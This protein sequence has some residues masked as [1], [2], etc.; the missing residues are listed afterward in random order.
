M[1]RDDVGET[2]LE[3]TAD[4]EPTSAE[5]ISPR[6]GRYAILRKLGQG[7]MGVVYSAY[8]ESLDR[9]VAL[10]FVRAD[11]K[12]ANRRI[13]REAQAMGRLSHPNVVQ[14]YEFGEHDGDLF[15]AMEF[16][17]GQTLSAWLKAEA[18]TWDTVRDVF[19]KAGRGLAAAHSAGLIHRDFKPDNVLVSRDAGVKVLDFGLVRRSDS[20]SSEA[21]HGRRA[22]VE[23]SVTEAGALMGTPA[24][25][26][27]EQFRGREADA[28]TDQFSFCVALWEGL[29]GERPFSG[30]TWQ[31][32]MLAV[33]NGELREPPRSSVVPQWLRRVIERGLSV[34]PARRWPSMEELLDALTA[35]PSQ[36]RRIWLAGTVA[37]ALLAG[38]FLGIPRWERLEEQRRL[39]E[40]E[41]S[42]ETDA[43]AV[44]AVWTS[45]QREAVIAAVG[46]G[47]ANAPEYEK[48]QLERTLQHLDGYVGQL[49]EARRSACRST[50]VDGTQSD[51]WLELRRRC[52]DSRHVDLEGLIRVLAEDSG[53]PP[54]DPVMSVL[55][56]P[57]IDL[58][59]QDSW[60]ETQPN[61]PE[62]PLLRE[63]VVDL[64]QELAH[65]GV[66]ARVGR[67]EQAL[68]LAESVFEQATLIDWQPLA[69]SA[70][71]QMGWANDNLGNYELARTQLNE[72]LLLAGSSRND[73]SM[74]GAVAALAWVDAYRLG[75]P[76]EGLQWAQ[77]GLMLAKRLDIEDSILHAEVLHGQGIAYFV[78]E[79]NER[80]RAAF[81]RALEIRARVVGQT[82][83]MIAAGHV[84]LGSVEI[85]AR[86]DEAALEHFEAALSIYHASLGPFHGDVAVA[87]SNIGTVYVQ[88]K[89][90]S[91]GLE[92]YGKAVDLWE[93]R[94]PEHPEVGT[95]LDNIGAAHYLSGDYEAAR[96]YHLRAV[97]IFEKSFGGDHPM[98]GAALSGLGRDE[99][100]LGNE[101]AAL[102]ALE[103]SLEIL[104]GSTGFSS[105]LGATRETLA[106]MLW[107]RGDAERAT[108]L[109]LAAYGDYSNGDPEDRL[110]LV[111]WFEVHAPSVALDTQPG[112]IIG[113]RVK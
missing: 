53:T 25:M 52:F 61:F 11:H 16:V 28:R 19:V 13:A 76:K 66:L 99:R 112:L 113:D 51:E 91:R 87:M 6:V 4:V 103:R 46:G 100:K 79:D 84:A 38:L 9:K 93:R 88:M 68:D 59:F 60:S 48:D 26:A 37:A 54:S 104:E 18:R 101:D 106:L 80:A 89:D 55:R 107:D 85:T 2:L 108:A 98:I 67:F 69:A 41:A 77:L 36:Q 15:I 44:E 33:C 86:N 32:L 8:D 82:H 111:E 109:M 29:H 22:H 110:R 40:F 35:D 95:E 50:L 94:G 65:A 30:E 5:E 92:Y 27:A 42:C 97:A 102:V 78:N 39:E 24:Y 12:S 62:D 10:K 70:R 17:P 7:G 49:S 43:R 71:L 75:K 56:L 58:C 14:V 23:L 72:A 3:I 20:T 21:Q 74:L 64:E 63:Q 83:P 90:Y 47:E 34:D 1:D 45:T 73:E 31:E 57:S 81:Q 96:T 105:Y